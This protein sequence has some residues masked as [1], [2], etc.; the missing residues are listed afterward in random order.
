MPCQARRPIGLW[1]PFFLSLSTEYLFLTLPFVI[2]R[3]ASLSCPSVKCRQPCLGPWSL[4]SLCISLAFPDCLAETRVEPRSSISHGPILELANQH[5]PDLSC[6]ES[7]IAKSHVPSDAC[8]LLRIEL[9]LG[10]NLPTATG[11]RKLFWLPLDVLRLYDSAAVH[12]KSA[13]NTIWYGFRQPKSLGSKT[14]CH[15]PIGE[16]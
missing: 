8:K 2:R 16:L 3:E 9:A 5:M 14:H 1:R 15:H 13:P 12:S 11:G 7:R 10:L 6:S 4:F